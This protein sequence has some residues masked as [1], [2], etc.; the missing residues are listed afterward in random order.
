MLTD[1][2]LIEELKTRFLE[3]KKLLT[4]QTKL[5]N[6]L[7]EVNKKLEESESL[8]SHFLSNIKNEIKAVIER[9]AKILDVLEEEEKEREKLQFMVNDTSP[10]G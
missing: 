4:E 5:T 9:Y 10:L 3:S 6:K 2:Q 8:K 1:D 7:Q